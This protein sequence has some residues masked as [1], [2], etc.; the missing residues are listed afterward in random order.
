MRLAV[1]VYGDDADE[2]ERLLVAEAGRL[3]GDTHWGLSSFEDPITVDAL[4]PGWPDYPRFMAKAVAVCV[5]SDDD[6]DLCGW[7]GG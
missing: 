4:D 2:L 7:S 1:T 3:V 6:P 5:R